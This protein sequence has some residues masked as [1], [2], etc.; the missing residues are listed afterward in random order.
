[1]PFFK[2][3]LLVQWN[4][5]TLTCFMENRSFMPEPDIPAIREIMSD[6]G[7]YYGMAVELMNQYQL[8]I[9]L[10]VLFYCISAFRC[11]EPFYQLLPLIVVL[12]GCLFTLIWEAMARYVFPYF[13]YMVPLSAIGW[14][15]MVLL[16]R[17]VRL[18]KR[19][20]V[21]AEEPV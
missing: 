6:E 17:K 13:I 12:G 7:K 18:I 15:Y 9:Y 20:T 19:G 16:L 5:P 2:E 14:G 10:G 4:D 1:M 11:R 3:K 21:K 8:L